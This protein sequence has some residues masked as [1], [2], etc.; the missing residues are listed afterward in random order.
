MKLE[1]RII[2]K[3]NILRDNPIRP[4]PLNNTSSPKAWSATLSSGEGF[5]PCFKVKLMF[6]HHW[7]TSKMEL[8]KPQMKLIYYHE[9][10]VTILGSFCNFALLKTLDFGVNNVSK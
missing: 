9:W 2:L 7:F 6:P 4:I 1:V 3:I 10:R 8:A 5:N